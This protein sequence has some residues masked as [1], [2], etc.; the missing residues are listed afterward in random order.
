[1]KGEVEII[2]PLMAKQYLATSKGNRFLKRGAVEKYAR[3]IKANKWLLN[4]ETIIFDEDGVLKD[5][6]HRM[7]AIIKAE[8]PIV[9][10]VVRGVPKED[11]ELIDGGC[12]RTVSDNLKMSGKDIEFYSTANVS[13][14]NFCIGKEKGIC[15]PSTS[16]VEDFILENYDAFC[17]CLDLSNK[18]KVNGIKFQNKVSLRAAAYY[19]YKNGVTKST[20]LRFFEVVNGGFY[21]SEKETAAIVFRNQ[22]MQGDVSHSRKARNNLF[23]QAQEAIDC[24]DKGLPRKRPFKGEKNIY[25]GK[26]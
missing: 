24:F 13:L 11:T 5:G 26:E 1:M 3:D 25:L 14:A 4:G 2:T 7:A 12:A 15:T 17:F 8:H 18:C 10:F 23:V 6:H 21:E 19:A 20:I 22:L 9:S 16:E